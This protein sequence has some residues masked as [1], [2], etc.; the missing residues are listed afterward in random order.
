MSN[1]FD[2][3][4]LPGDNDNLPPEQQETEDKLAFKRYLGGFFR[5]IHVPDLS[6]EERAVLLALFQFEQYV[7]APDADSERAQG[8]YKRVRQLIVDLQGIR[9]SG[10]NGFTEDSLI[11]RMWKRFG[12]IEKRLP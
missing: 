6:Q 12:D 9:K 11:K 8:F 4:P 1:T 10:P 2:G 5:D 7:S 3:P